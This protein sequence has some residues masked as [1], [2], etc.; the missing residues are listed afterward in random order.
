MNWSRRFQKWYRKQL[1]SRSNWNRTSKNMTAKGKSWKKKMVKNNQIWKI[2]W[3][4]WYLK[5]KHK[6][7]KLAHYPSTSKT[8]PRLSRNYVNKS[9]IMLKITRYPNLNLSKI[10]IIK[11]KSSISKMKCIKIKYQV[12]KQ[13]L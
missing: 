13:K 2:N 9:L 8:R 12:S 7:V 3:M 5:C 1:S 10:W 11:S 6:T 4:N